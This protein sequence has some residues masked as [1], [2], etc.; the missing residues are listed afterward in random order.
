MTPTATRTATRTAV[1]LATVLVAGLLGTA[2]AA[3]AAPY[4]GLTWG[5]LAKTAP[6]TTSPSLVGVRSGRQTCFDRLVLDLGAGRVSGY[7]VRY[8]P[9][10]AKDGSGDIVPTRGGADLQVVVHAPAYDDRGA[11]TYAPANPAEIAPVAGF[12]TFRQVVWADSFEGQSTVGI[13]VRAR[14]PFRAFVLA[15]PGGGS[16]LVVD[17]AHQW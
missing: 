8:V 15:G 12:R 13:G 5:S 6:A 2:P 1:G 10:I 17:V 9:H 4:C 3:H 16:R 14:L 11:T 7:D